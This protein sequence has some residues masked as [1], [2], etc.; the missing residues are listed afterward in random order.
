[1]FENCMNFAEK[2]SLPSF[3]LVSIGWFLLLLASCVRGAHWP[4]L[5]NQKGS[6]K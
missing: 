5:V 6:I 2:L 3:L 4:S 1:M